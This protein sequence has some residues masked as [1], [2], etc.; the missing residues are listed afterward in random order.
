MAEANNQHDQAA[1]ALE[2]LAQGVSRNASAHEE[3][4]P[5]PSATSEEQIASEFLAD[6]PT[7]PAVPIRPDRNTHNRASQLYMRVMTPALVV[8]GVVLLVLASYA[9]LSMTYDLPVTLAARARWV[10]LA[11]F[12]V[13][14]ICLLGAWWF[15]RQ[16]RTTRR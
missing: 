6:A 15:H 12:P 16:S 5:V 8:V 10:I 7:Y 13:G 11:A 2:A 9:V 14:A 4:A 3:S 1:D